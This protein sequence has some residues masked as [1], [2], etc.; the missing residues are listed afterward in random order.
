MAFLAP[1]FPLLL[2][3]LIGLLFAPGGSA[4][5]LDLQAASDGVHRF[6]VIALPAGLLFA[7][8]FLLLSVIKKRS[9]G[10]RLTARTAM[11]CALGVCLGVLVFI[12]RFDSVIEQRGTAGQLVLPDDHRDELRWKPS[13]RLADEDTEYFMG[14]GYLYA[15]NLAIAAVDRSSG[16]LR[17]IFH[18]LG[19]AVSDATIKGGRLSFKAHRPSVTTSYVLDL[20]EPR[21]LSFREE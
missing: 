6:A 5:Y 14:P 8:V 7:L 10:I 4:G 1:W 17:W 18:C 19:N 3:I 16:R 9:A 20:S 13:V 12:V 2:G 11:G 15:D 21:V